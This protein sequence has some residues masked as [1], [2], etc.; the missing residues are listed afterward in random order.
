MFIGV[1]QTSPVFGDKAANRKEIEKLT[2]GAHADLWVIPELALTGYEFKDREETRTL[3]KPIPDSESCE[4]LA[5][6]CKTKN[7]HAV[8]GLAERSNTQVFNSAVMMG[9]RGY[10]GLYR[11]IHL[12]DREKELFDPGDMPFPV[13]KVGDARVG[14]MICFDW[15]FPEAARTLALRGAQIIAHP[16]NL[17]MPYCQ[18]AMVTR[19]LENGVFIATANR[20][21]T[22]RRVAR[23]LTFTGGSQIV[24][25]NGEILATAPVSDAAVAV[26]EIIPS[27]ADNKHVTMWN[28][29]IADRR[30]DFY[31]G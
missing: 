1:V 18:Q 26:S 28:D 11:K 8:M 6:F 16:S 25:P 13:F 23:T 24:A 30:P 4:W 22:E 3:S 9:P 21:G 31:E 10:A 19:A 15:R 20:V 7:C 2:A 17:V 12:F 14:L 27:T 29:L 5:E